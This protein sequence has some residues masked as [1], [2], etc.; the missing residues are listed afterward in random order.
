MTTKG[1]G[2]VNVPNLVCKKYSEAEFII[3]GSK[4]DVSVI[5][6]GTVTSLEDAYIWKQSPS[7]SAGRTLGVGGVIDVWVTKRPPSDCN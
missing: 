4:L 7:Y 5:Q 6:D 3:G 1:G 2:R